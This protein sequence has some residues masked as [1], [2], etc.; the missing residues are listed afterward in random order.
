M[1]IIKKSKPAKAVVTVKMDR[2]I[3]EQVQERADE[4]GLT[5]TA[6]INVLV[7]EFTRTG[8]LT[9]HEEL[10][11]TPYLEKILREYEDDKKHGRDLG[12]TLRTSKEL[13]DYFAKLRRRSTRS[14]KRRTHG[15]TVSSSVSKA[16]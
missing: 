7:R 11:P 1:K 15:R 9:D 6:V 3:K 16:A 8:R 13:H 10:R 12:P 5:M 2:R 14:N 4:L